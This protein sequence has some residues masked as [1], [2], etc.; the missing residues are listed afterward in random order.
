MEDLKITAGLI[1]L[2]ES[3]DQSIKEMAE[4]IATQQS[5]ISS[6]TENLVQM[7]KIMNNLTAQITVLAKMKKDKK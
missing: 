4:I 1:K 7:V 2:S 6:L 5:Q 3:S